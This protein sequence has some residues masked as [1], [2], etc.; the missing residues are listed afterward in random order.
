M[1][2]VLSRQ[3][4]GPVT[5]DGEPALRATLGVGPRPDVASLRLAMFVYRRAC[6]LMWLIVA[7]I[8]LRPA[9]LQ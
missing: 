5:Y 3:L 8:A 2:G 7:A 1:A 9:W 4:G 6:G